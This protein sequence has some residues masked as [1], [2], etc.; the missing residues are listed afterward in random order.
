[1]LD[2]RKKLAA[3]GINF[4]GDSDATTC[5]PDNSIDP[6][7]ERAWRGAV[8]VSHLFNNDLRNCTLDCLSFIDITTSIFYRLLRFSA[9][10]ESPPESAVHAAYHIGILVF[11]MTMLAQRGRRQIIKCDLIFQRLRAVLESGQDACDDELVFWVTVMGGIW[12]ADDGDSEWFDSRIRALAER[13]D[14]NSWEA[15]RRSL[16]RFPWIDGLHDE[17]GRELW[18]RKTQGIRRH[19]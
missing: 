3:K 6:D 19:H 8:A 13:L 17:P 2:V 18:D 1:M 9:L 5:S 10:S 4:D 14:L 7:L 12:V 11:A 16:C 15:A